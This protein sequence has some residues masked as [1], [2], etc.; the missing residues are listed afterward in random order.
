MVF[1]LV[2]VWTVLLG[3]AVFYYVVFDGFDLGVG[4]GD[5]VVLGIPR[6]SARHC[7]IPLNPLGTGPRAHVGRWDLE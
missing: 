3:L 6:Q 7:R 1:D 2:P 5:L 4:W